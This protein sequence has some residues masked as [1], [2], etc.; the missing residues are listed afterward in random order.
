LDGVASWSGILVNNAA[1]QEHVNGFEDLSEA[2]F[3]RTIKTNLYG[4]FHMVKAAVPQMKPGCAIVM[5]GSATGLVGNRN[6]LVYSMTE[7][8]IHAFAE[9]L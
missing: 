5:T 8:G 9:L 4:Y 3:D 6:L 2:H 1:F 7:G